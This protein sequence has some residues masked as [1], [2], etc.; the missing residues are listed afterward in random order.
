MAW[1]ELC[2]MGALRL[3]NLIAQGEV[4]AREVTEAHVRQVE[5]LNPL[6]NAIVT[7]TPEDALA[8]AD[9]AD[10]AFGRG[11]LLGPLHGL[12]VAYKDLQE[13]R[14][15]R[16][17]Y[18]SIGYADFHP[19]FDSLLV[20]R[21]NGAGAISL[22]KTNTPEFGTGSH[23]YNSLFGPTRNPYDLSKSAGGSSGGAAAALASGMVALA[24]GSDMAGSLRNPAS[25]CN[26]VGLRPTPGRVPSWPAPA[27]WFPLSVDGPMGRSVGDVA[28]MLSV[29][30]GEDS[31][32]PLSIP[33]D[34]REFARVLEPPPAGVRV[35]WSRSAGGLQI[36]PE[37][38]RVLD[39]FGR[40]SLVDMGCVVED[41]EPDFS[42]ADE[43][44]LTWRAW[45]YAL[46]LGEDLDRHG[47]EL[48]SDVIANIELGRRLSGHDLARAE[49]LRTGLW[50]RMT[51]LFERF[52]VL[53][54]PAAQVMPFDV[55]QKWVTEINGHPQSSYLDWM[56]AA[57]RISATGLPAISVPCGF[58]TDGRPVGLQLVGRPH[59]ELA[60]LE[61]AHAFEQARGGWSPPRLGERSR[62]PAAAS[63]TG[64]TDVTCN[65]KEEG[66]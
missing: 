61:I 62:I 50:H 20:Q 30:A 6:I 57:Y 37:V 66:R 17:T 39:S 11:E 58:S 63:P 1:N 12:P 40:A 13:T 53:A 56:R 26:I 9:E 10:R 59:R 45:Y 3:R 48:N 8:R 34:G 29:L 23:T 54:L 52:D 21:V 42:G 28:L 31:R 64:A 7:F 25:F 5:S 49:V 22:G 19:V 44:F 27:A 16:T 36:D 32:S 46:A 60:L 15:V 65:F 43:S 41:V 24:D 55:E 47:S 33:G 14:G 35:A 2:G 38:T 51:E 18:G 4:S